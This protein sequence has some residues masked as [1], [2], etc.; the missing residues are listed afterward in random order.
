M[1]GFVTDVADEWVTVA[2]NDGTTETYHESYLRPV[3]IEPRT[4]T[5]EEIEYRRWITESNVQKGRS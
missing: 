5:R 2:W 1:R 4:L 3:L